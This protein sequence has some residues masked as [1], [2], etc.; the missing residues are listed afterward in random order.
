MKKL[1]FY[2]LGFL[3]MSNA[4]IAQRKISGLITDSKGELLIGA[5]IV[6]KENTAVGT[7]SDIDGKF[8]LTVPNDVKSLLVSYTGF[9][10]LEV[11]LST[12][13]NYTMCA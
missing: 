8:E 7:I 9:S 12:E 10:S 4:A 1:I 3:L 5:N 2:V 13:T 6:A 11:I